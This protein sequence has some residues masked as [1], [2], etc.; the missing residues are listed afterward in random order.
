MSQEDDSLEAVEYNEKKKHNFNNQK[1]HWDSIQKGTSAQ[2]TSTLN[3]SFIF[4]SD[5]DQ[6]SH[7]TILTKEEMIKEF[8]IM[9]KNSK[10]KDIKLA[11]FGWEVARLHEENL[12][13][14]DQLIKAKRKKTYKNGNKKNDEIH[15][16]AR[17]DLVDSFAESEIVKFD[18]LSN[19]KNQL[20]G[21]KNN[22]KVLAIEHIEK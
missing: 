12:R 9:K 5:E 8:E 7:H 19:E 10:E 13:L 1:Y 22:K 16:Y 4:E 3:R 17:Y 18:I 15:E 11:K 2:K 21:R 20:E 6:N 14:K